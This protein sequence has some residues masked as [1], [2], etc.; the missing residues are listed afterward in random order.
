MFQI[1]CRAWLGVLLIGALA[2]LP[3][4]AAVEAQPPSDPVILELGGNLWAWEGADQP[5]VQLTSWG[6]NQEPILSPDGTKA[7]Y[8][9][10]ARIFAEWLEEVGGGG[11]FQPPLNIWVLDVPT[12]EP[13]R[14][15]DQPVDAVWEGPVAPGK[16]TLRT[17]PAWSPDSQ[18]L[19]WVELQIDTISSTGAQVGTA[20]LVTYELASSSTHVLDSFPIFEDV[21]TP[22]TFDVQ[23]GRPGIALKT[24]LQSAAPELRVYDPSGDILAESEYDEQT[25]QDWLRTVW[26]A[27][28]DDDYLFRTNIALD[29]LWQH[30][31]TGEIEPIDGLPEIASSSVPDGARFFMEG[32]SWHLALPGQDPLDLG[33]QVRPFGISRD[34]Q[35]ALYERWEQDTDGFFKDTLIVQSA[36]ESIEVGRYNNVLP[37]WGPVTWQIR[38]PE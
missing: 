8:T 20:D 30:W 33:D 13:F 38:Q 3:G 4:L 21:M 10:M 25:S 31:Q 29:R 35:R 12:R 34:G 14:V 32:E 36:A 7:A 2:W 37:V 5:M 27:D 26:I 18:S 17:R 1:R 24:H 6:L 22:D 9:S 15:A 19:A 11:G 23:W 16:Y 28:Q